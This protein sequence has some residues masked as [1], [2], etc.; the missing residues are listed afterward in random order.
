MS[1]KKTA[2]IRKKQIL[3]IEDDFFIADMYKRQL[4]MSGYGV[5]LSYDAY[6]GEAKLAKKRYDLILL[7]LMLPGKNGM[8][9]LRELK[10]EART[11]DIPVVVVSNLGRSDVV[12]K[13][14]EL[15]AV[16]YI[17]KSQVTPMEIA[18]V[19]EREVPLAQAT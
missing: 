13:A 16:Q 11:K 3:L 7:D 18:S 10:A 15:G 1:T 17:T 2:T 9:L 5:D 4:E 8:D 6:A 12:V 14:L 19:V